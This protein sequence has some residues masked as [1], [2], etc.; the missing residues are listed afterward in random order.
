MTK[1][2]GSL[3]RAIVLLY[4][5]WQCRSCPNKQLVSGETAPPVC[6]GRRMAFWRPER[7]AQRGR[8]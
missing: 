1:N 3:A 4:P 8:A 2:V 5:Q 7:T 6:C